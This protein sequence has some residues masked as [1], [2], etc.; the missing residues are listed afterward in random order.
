MRPE[1]P[2]AWQRHRR[3]FGLQVGEKMM[4]DVIGADRVNTNNITLLHLAYS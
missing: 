2:P 3:L 1:T 4:N